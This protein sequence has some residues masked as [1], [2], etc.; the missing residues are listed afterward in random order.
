MLEHHAWIHF[1]PELVLEWKQAQ[2]EGRDV[3]LLRAICEE[4]AKRSITENKT[5]V[6]IA[7]KAQLDNAPMIKGYPFIEPSDYPGIQSAKPNRRHK[8]SVQLSDEILFDKIKGAWIGRISGCLLG[9]P[10]EGWLSKDLN[11]LLKDSANYPMDRYIKLSEL[12]PEWVKK[13]DPT[14]AWADTL[15]GFAPID[16]DTN[17][18]VLALKL[19]QTYG[20]DFRP[21]DVL[22]AWLTWMPMLATCTA[23]RVAY[24]NA[25]MGLL[26]PETATTM[27]PYREWIGAQI[28]ADFF[29]YINVG[30][31][32]LAAEMAFRDASIS[33]IKNGIYGEML[34]AA[35]IA[36]AA[37]SDDLL[38]IIEAGLDEI[39]ARC[40]LRGDIQAVLSHHREQKS[41]DETIALIH[42]LYDETS[43]H[44]WC[45]T[46]PN[47]MIVVTALLYGN[48][49]FS[50][51]LG[52]SV[53]AG[54]DTDCN[55]A[56]LGSLLGMLLGA[57]SI[58][59]EW[60]QPHQNTL[61]TSLI[62]FNSVT[63]DELVQ[64]TLSI[65]KK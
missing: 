56:T 31:P 11:K 49:D 33:H 12:T 22:E 64:E 1:A 37:V 46:N 54:F 6:A 61:A 18:T 59:D 30:D 39:P 58:P 45:H 13:A 3:K 41:Y 63:V 17:Y 48:K 32:D 40:R 53:Q 52:M 14:R 44:G 65:L 34:M 29:G 9:K 50:K 8:F 47:A 28:R 4:V 16:D 5:E 24:R 62:G 43:G 36:A 23:E 25:S 27:N 19:V 38:T 21:N 51:S 7:I 55:G 60:I 35:M 42:K 20:K 57:Q 2:D 10:V 15:T 26:A